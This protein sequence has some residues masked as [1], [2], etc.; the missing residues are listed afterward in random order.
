MKRLRAILW[1]VEFTVIG[2]LVV[3]GTVSGLA[4]L[5]GLA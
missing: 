5:F 1:R 3:A 4:R 2:A